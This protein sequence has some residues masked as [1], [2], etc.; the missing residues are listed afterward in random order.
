[1]LRTLRASASESAIARRVPLGGLILGAV[2]GFL[3]ISAPAA[4]SDELGGNP[5]GGD[6][7]LRLNADVITNSSIG[8]GGSSDFPVKAELFLPEMARRAGDRAASEAS[9]AQAVGILDFRPRSDRQVVEDHQRIRGDLFADYAPRA[10]I[11]STSRD[12]EQADGLWYGIIAAVAIPLVVL[13]A[14]TG[15]KNASRSV[16]RHARATH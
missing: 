1:M 16:N 10:V 9:I 5:S 13:A 8:A 4:W 3:A 7:S 12:A 15:R 2:V 11:S 14:W 6:G